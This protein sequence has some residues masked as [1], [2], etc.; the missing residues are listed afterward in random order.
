MAVLFTAERGKRG[1]TNVGAKF[2]KLFTE[3]AILTTAKHDLTN[4]RWCLEHCV[5]WPGSG[6][7]PFCLLTGSAE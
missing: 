1:L 6:S 5:Y 3:A 2:R 4:D 7:G